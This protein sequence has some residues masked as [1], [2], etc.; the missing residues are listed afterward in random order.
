[1]NRRLFA[2]LV[3]VLLAGPLHAQG[4]RRLVAY[5][6]EW[7]IHQRKYFV[8]DIPADKLTHVNY[9]F[10]KIA[11]GVCVPRNEIDALGEPAGAG[12]LGQ[13]QKLKEQHKHLKTLV[14]IGGWSL[15]GPFS[16]A[17]LTPGSRQKFARSC[18]EFIMKHG[19]DG[20]DIDWEYPVTGGKDP[21]RAR[22]EDKQNFTLLL[23]ELRKE[24]DARGK[25]DRARFLLTIAGPG[26]PDH[27]TNIEL[28][29]IAPH[30]DWI[31]LIVYNYFGQ[32][33]KLTNFRAPLFASKNDP[34]QRKLHNV[35]ATVNA[36]LKAG[37]PADKLVVG[38]SFIGRGWGEVKD[39][40]NGLY[41][42]HGPAPKGTWQPGEFDYRDL[43]ANYVGKYKRFWHADAEAPW[44]FDAKSGI[45]ISYEDPESLRVK[46]N[47]VNN[48]RLGG[49]MCWEL[50]ADDAK[51]SLVS[52]L[53]K[54]LREKK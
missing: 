25:D 6:P 41:Q 27:Y 16:D 19:F 2:S 35:D 45:M 9:A 51:H 39:V 18:V 21:T 24:L 22:P 53:N 36:Y 32:T 23:Q 47:Y 29:K 15:S 54:A 14:S 50:S 1:M 34:G 26:G 38:V 17:A 48:K 13:L 7:G 33:S 10:A 46:A 5:F 20:I 31:N 12:T 37:I 30:V 4:E 42:P 49:V 3:V 44:L 52:A 28:D 40:D 11:G 43:A 8:K